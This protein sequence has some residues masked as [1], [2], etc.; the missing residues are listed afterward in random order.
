MRFGEGEVSV[1]PVWRAI[2][3]FFVGRNLTL[4]P[5]RTWRNVTANVFSAVDG[6]RIL[7]EDDDSLPNGACSTSPAP[8]R[9]IACW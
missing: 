8:A 6:K 9:G 1:Q 3:D 2:D 7:F 5:G 4:P